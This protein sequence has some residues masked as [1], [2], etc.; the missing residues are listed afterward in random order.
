MDPPRGHT[1]PL[2]LTIPPLQPIN[3][4]Q[5]IVMLNH[6]TTIRTA[7][8]KLLNIYN[9][10]SSRLLERALLLMLMLILP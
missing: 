1:R 4:S 9:F 3:P 5:P 8:R 2:D 6:F 10:P 7:P